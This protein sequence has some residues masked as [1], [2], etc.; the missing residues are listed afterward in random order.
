MQQRVDVSLLTLYPNQILETP[1]DTIIV[2][3]LSEGSGYN[4]ITVSGFAA[5]QLAY[6]SPRTFAIQQMRSCIDRK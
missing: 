5:V 4:Y 1:A 2:Q 3:L 6:L